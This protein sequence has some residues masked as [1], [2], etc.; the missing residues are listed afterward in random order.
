MHQYVLSPY[1]DWSDDEIRGYG[2]SGHASGI[3]P[4]RT[5][6][7]VMGSH[8]IERKSEPQSAEDTHYNEIHACACSVVEYAIG[9]LKCRQRALDASNSQGVWCFAQHGTERYQ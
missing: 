9:L 2:A 6:V 4:I 5:K 8:D 1:S 3:A 7:E